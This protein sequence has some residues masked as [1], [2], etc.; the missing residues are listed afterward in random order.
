[1]HDETF[2]RVIP[3][4]WLGRSTC[5]TCGRRWLD[6]DRN[7][8]TFDRSSYSFGDWVDQIGICDIDE[9]EGKEDASDSA[10]AHGWWT[11]MRSQTWEQQGEYEAVFRHQRNEK[12]LAT[13]P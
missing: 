4:S 1:M 5:R 11:L 8:P 10:G 7:S 12:S 6:H 9:T 13:L 3:G 2:Q